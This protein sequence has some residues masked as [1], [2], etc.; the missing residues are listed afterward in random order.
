MKKTFRR[1]SVTS[2]HGFS[3]R[4][5]FHGFFQQ[6]TTPCALV[7]YL[8]GDVA[9]VVLDDRPPV[10]RVT[11]LDSPKERR[12][13]KPRWVHQM[14]T[15]ETGYVWHEECACETCMQGHEAKVAEMNE[16]GHV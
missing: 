9:I 11:F 16:W 15:G 14:R 12:K 4:A 5:W 6:G 13:H 1:V 3:A 10:M 8:N 2:A 7:E